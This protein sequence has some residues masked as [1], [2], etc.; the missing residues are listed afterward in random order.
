MC[1]PPAISLHRKHTCSAE[2]MICVRVCTKVTVLLQNCKHVSID[3]FWLAELSDLKMDWAIF[4]LTALQMGGNWWKGSHAYNKGRNTVLV[5][6][7]LPLPNYR[8]DL[9]DHHGSSQR[10][11]IMGSAVQDLH[12]FLF[13]NSLFF[14]HLIFSSYS[15]LH[16]LCLVPWFVHELR[17]YEG[18]FLPGDWFCYGLH[19]FSGF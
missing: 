8:A 17:A 15:I 12:P 6:S 9:D 14:L 18:S 3:P 2:L 4:F 19:I 1:I 7:K 16:W 10:Q 5:V 13:S 11:V